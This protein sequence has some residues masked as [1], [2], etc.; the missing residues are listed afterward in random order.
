MPKL[1]K[2]GGLS[3]VDIPMAPMIDIVFQ[4][5]IF[6]MLNL[7][8][9]APEGNFNVN[10]PITLQ[11]FNGRGRGEI[12]RLCFAEGKISFED[13]RVDFA[14]WGKVKP[15]TP[16]GNM[17]VLT[18][19]DGFVVSESRAVDRAAARLANV[20]GANDA[21]RNA[22]DF[23]Y[24]M[25]KDAF[26]QFASKVFGVKN[27]EELKKKNMAEFF[28]N[29][30]PPFVKQTEAVLADGRNYV[31]GKTANV[32]LADLA[33][34]DFFGS[35]GAAN[36]ASLEHATHIKALIARVGARSNIAAW[37]AARPNTPW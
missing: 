30:L 13:K 27:D 18:L 26:D 4:L 12:S 19:A 33:V 15:T 3:K 1:A 34:F 11:Y 35:I 28:T 14:E 5:L 6:F 25:V 24:E 21:E 17:P 9:V 8:I 7:K 20:Y 22:I 16:L 32:S 31:G 36:P 23:V 37:V 29:T 2:T 10:M